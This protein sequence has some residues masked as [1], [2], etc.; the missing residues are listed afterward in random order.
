[1]FAGQSLVGVPAAFQESGDGGL[2]CEMGDEVEVRADSGHRPVSGAGSVSGV[3][4]GFGVDAAVLGECLAPAGEASVLG[5]GSQPQDFAQGA[6]LQDA[7]HDGGDSCAAGEVSGDTAG[8]NA[9]GRAEDKV[10]LRKQWSDSVG[11]IDDVK[12]QRS[13]G[14]VGAELGEFLGESCDFG[15]ADVAVAGG[16]AYEVVPGEPVGVD[17]GEVS[18]AVAGEGVRGGGSDAASADEQDLCC[19]EVLDG[20][21]VLDLADAGGRRL[22]ETVEG[23]APSC[24][25]LQATMSGTSWSGKASVRLGA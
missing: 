13:D 1:M 21:V 19:L 9:V 11:V 14:R 8:G 2:G 7:G 6:V 12:D 20:P 25:T 16:V 17:E 5:P 10:A 4:S 22:D 15:A 24:P 18:D 3:E 23:Y